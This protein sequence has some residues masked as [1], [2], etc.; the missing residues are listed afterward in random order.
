MSGERHSEDY[1]HKEREIMGT[2]EPP[3]APQILIAEDDAALRRLLEM[4]FVDEGYK[5]RTAEDGVEALVAIEDWTPDAII[6]DV[7][8]PRL[9]GLTVCRE[10]RASSIT[11]T[12]PIVLLTARCFD[13]DIQAVMELG[14][15][16]YLAKPFDPRRLLTLIADAVKTTTDGAQS[17]SGGGLGPE[18]RFVTAPH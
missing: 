2:A 11:E 12:V 9:S 4:V 3:W 8:M 17:A 10:V 6:C 13:E 18:S 14:G 15:M 16:T 1:A 7:M 5:V